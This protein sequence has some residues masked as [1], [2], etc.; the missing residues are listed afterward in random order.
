MI[1]R[2]IITGPMG[3][4]WRIR[5]KSWEESSGGPVD[6]MR[7]IRPSTSFPHSAPLFPHSARGNPQHNPPRAVDGEGTCRSIVTMLLRRPGGCLLRRRLD[8]DR[9]F[10]RKG[11][12]HPFTP[13]LHVMASGRAAIQVGHGGLCRPSTKWRSDLSPRPRRPRRPGPGAPRI[14]RLRRCL[15]ESWDGRTG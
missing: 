4:L 3:R 13:P 5:R 10:P 2:K 12:R 9:E 6:E 14:R 11:R 8:I 7:R 1:R 15:A